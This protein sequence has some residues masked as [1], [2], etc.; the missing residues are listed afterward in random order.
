MNLPR[1]AALMALSCCL[2]W[3]AFA[4]IPVEVSR[5]ESRSIV[6]QINVNGTV[7][8]PRTAI[9]ST[10][11][12]G[13]VAQLDI[14]EGDRVLRGDPLL[15]LD[16]ELAQLAL[17]RVLAQV[18]L[19]EA[20]LADAKRRFKQ[21]REVGAERGIARTEIESLEAEVMADQATLTAALAAASEQQA[22]L[23]RHTVAAPF[24]GVVSQRLAELG[25]WINPGDGLLELV[26]TENLRFDFQVG[27]DYYAA[28]VD[29]AGIEITLD[30]L[31]GDRLTGEVKTIVPIKDATARTF[32]VRVPAASLQAEKPL[33]VT[34]GMSARGRLAV[35]TGQQGLAVSR[36]AILRFPDG[37]VTV[38]VVEPDG[39]QNTVR[40][41]RVRTG[42]EF[43]G[44]VEITEG[45]TGDEVV[46]TRGNET[47]LEGQTVSL[48]N[49]SS[50]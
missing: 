7:T 3:D 39:E 30:A 50:T 47:L 17:D 37:R 24:A 15:V 11:V 42:L 25:E 27:Q 38:W 20:E 41:Q 48:V 34:P 9:L 33:H 28:L 26:A 49:G 8:S 12:A 40:E 29:G 5:V 21:A 14:E 32:L 10:A 45:L 16:S 4:Q 36:D 19:R 1:L 43:D 46:V 22:L 44:M 13:L 6:R 18:A 2:A 23:K 35:S 31:P